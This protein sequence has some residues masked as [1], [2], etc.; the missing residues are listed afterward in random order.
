[1]HSFRNT[2]FQLTDCVVLQHVPV[3]IVCAAVWPQQLHLYVTALCLY[4]CLT[5]TAAPTPTCFVCVCSCLIATAAPTRTCFVC[6]QLFDRDSCTYTYPFCVCAAVW[7]RQLHLH[8]S[9]FCV[10]SCLTATAAPT[11]TCFLCVQLFDRDSYTYTYLFLCLCAAVWPRQLH[12]H[13]SVLC[14]CSCLTATA[15]P[16]RTCWPTGAPPRQY[17]STP[18]W[19]SRAGMQHLSR[20]WNS[21]SSTWVSRAYL[22]CTPIYHIC[23]LHIYHNSCTHKYPY[24]GVQELSLAEIW[25]VAYNL[26]WRCPCRAVY[27]LLV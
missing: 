19:T 1:M 22:L 11:R 14:V 7:P 20:S 2:K 3:L 21:S 10:C 13:V 17:S 23:I 12:L 18:S 26:Y 15:A 27:E 9:V 16:T 4:S 6:V 8:V 24:W 25:K 5:A